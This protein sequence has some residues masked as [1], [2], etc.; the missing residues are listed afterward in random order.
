[1]AQ[2]LHDLETF[3]TTFKNITGI[4]VIDFY[5]SWCGPCKRIAPFYDS[6]VEKYPNV[7]FFKVDSGQPY[8]KDVV[9]ACNVRSLPTFCFFIDEKYVES[10]IGANEQ[11]LEATIQKYLQLQTEPN[12]ENDSTQ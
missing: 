4:S 2:E 6:L 3:A 8:M 7:K 1:M 9:T 12:N 5:A 11:V 10:V